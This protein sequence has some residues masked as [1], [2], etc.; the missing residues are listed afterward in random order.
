MI[1][2]T[3]KISL[4]NKLPNILSFLKNLFAVIFS[5]QIIVFT[6]LLIWYF[7]NPIK[8]IYT[9]KRIL[10][11]INQKSKNSVGFE[12]S[13]LGTYFKV[14]SLGSFYSV[15]KPEIETIDIDIDQ[16]NLLKL[17][18][19]RKNRSEINGS[20]QKL[21]KT[22]SK[23]AKGS[24]KYKNKKI[25]IKL[26]VKGDRRIHY[27][28]ASS[29]SY[30]IDLR[31]GK[32]IWGLEEFSLQKP[33]IRNYAYEY[34]FQKLNHELGNLSLNYKLVDLSINGIDHGIYSIEEG[35]SKELL[36]RH[37][38]R[39]GPIYGIKDDISGIYPDV[40]YDS[41]SEMKWVVN[42]EQLLRSGYGIL[43]TIRENGKDF[44]HHIDWDAWGKFFATTDLVETYHGAIA[45]S[46][47]VYYNPISGKIEPISFDGHHGT[48]DFKNFIILD[49]LNTEPN[50]SWICEEKE[51]FLRFLLDEN[52]LPRKEFLNSY[53]KHLKYITSEEF[54]EKFSNKYS[55]KIMHLNKLFYSDFSKYDNI[56]WKGIFPYVY[57]K[58]YL[59]NRAKE[60]NQKLNSTNISNFLF[61][62]KNDKLQ[63]KFARESIP[64]KI[65]PECDNYLN[66]KILETELWVRETRN[67]AWH[68]DCNSLIV[69]TI[70]QR[71]F[72]FSLIDSPILNISLPLTF[73]KL[74][75]IQ[76]KIEGKIIDNNF[77]PKNKNIVLSE[78]IV[79][80][81]EITLVIKEDQK[82]IL[83]HG[84]SL[85]LLGNIDIKGTKE[86]QSII[87]G[88][89]PNYGSIIS[90]NN[91]FKAKNLKIRNLI[92]PKISGYTF[93]A[94]V[95]IL[96]ADVDL[97]NI[98]FLNSLSED[99]LNL[100][101]SD[102]LINN[103]T[104]LNTKSDAL[105][106]DSGSSKIDNLKCE[107][108]G[109]DCLDFSNAKILANNIFTNNV[110]DKSISVGENSNVE[111][112]NLNIN[113]SEVGIAVKDNSIARINLVNIKKSKLPIAVFVK[114]NEYGPAELT[115]NNFNISD[116]NDV[117]LVDNISKLVIEGINYE[118]SLSGEIIESSLYGNKYGKATIR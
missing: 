28:D 105:D 13:N 109:N 103:L 60:I 106:V 39:N 70:D 81:K 57:D 97:N 5:I 83:S 67:I 44:K 33:I 93:Y 3:K 30:K 50:C 18:F 79:L 52:D 102:S 114:K 38:K 117:Y 112:N 21:K 64:I 62:K 108:I 98:T 101:N 96:N 73:E 91:I 2:K 6:F 15:F 29:T 24:I 78:N 27:T 34:I 35:F 43:N 74:P 113:N 53:I 66:N 69:E 22:L 87:E 75:Y 94:G 25:P 55:D 48:A 54:L 118:G 99:T 92:A 46:V 37:G 82:I 47:R 40:I 23:Y 86:K 31:K 72:P 116:S 76:N 12:I 115:I 58:D 63:I 9:P 77:F 71:N 26:R 36:E 51:W 7:N 59:K 14:Y 61:S 107:N 110:D 11:I 16:K 20:N 1:F 111:I 42:D 104:F 56:F 32:R 4:K 19:Q 17:E 89:Q 41:Y 85:V 45:K 10:D 100:I 68:N 95:N 88:V 90:V 49:F 8:T 65:K 84:S 80:P